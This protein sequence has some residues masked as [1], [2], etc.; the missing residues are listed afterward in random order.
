MDMYATARQ[1]DRP[2]AAINFPS[3]CILLFVTGSG[4]LQYVCMV[5]LKMCDKLAISAVKFIN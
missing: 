5:S 4:A 1:V 2:S 3:H